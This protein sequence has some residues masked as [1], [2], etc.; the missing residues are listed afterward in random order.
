MNLF[1]LQREVSDEFPTFR[2]VGKTTNRFMQVLNVL[3]LIVTF[4]QQKTFMT[5]FI[6]TIGTT[7]YVPADWI[8]WSD[9]RRMSILRH[10]RVHM[11]QARRYTTP[12]FFFLYLV[13]FLP[14]GLAYCRARFEWEAYTESMRADREYNGPAILG[15]AL[16]KASIVD[17]F[18]TGQYGWM[19]PFRKTVEGWYDAA[20]KDILASS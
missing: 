11:R 6:T 1:E 12:L 20:A 13:P 17:H 19:W 15:N 18:T 7:M 9:M 5:H 3:L 2:I 8:L 14:V 4:G 10:E 16:Y